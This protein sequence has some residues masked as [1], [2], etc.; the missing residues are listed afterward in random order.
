VGSVD[1]IQRDSASDA[2]SHP[3]S[4]VAASPMAT[5]LNDN[6]NC[7]GVLWLLATVDIKTRA[8]TRTEPARSLT[9]SSAIG[10]DGAPIHRKQQDRNQHGYHTY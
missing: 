6:D 4:V 2:L 8:E 10:H 7:R 5:P 9:L 1:A 3:V